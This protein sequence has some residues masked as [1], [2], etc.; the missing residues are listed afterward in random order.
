MNRRFVTFSTCAAAFV[1]VGFVW[2]MP[3]AWATNTERFVLDDADALAAGEL[4]RTSVH[5]DGR[6]TVGAELR[7]IALPDD[8]P[9]AYSATRASDGTI[10][11]GT[12]NDGRVYRLRGD[13]LELFASTGQLMVTALAIGDGGALYAGTMPE[14]R[15]YRIGADGQPNEIARP[16]GVEHVWDVAWD[17]RRNV[18]YA[19]TGPEGRVYAIDRQGNA[20]IYWDSS[21]SHVMSLALGADGALYAGTSDDA[22]VAR[23]TG[24]GHATIVHDFEGNEITA[25]AFRDGVLAVGANEF[26]DPPSLTNTNAQE[27]TSTTTT[28]PVPRPGKGRIWRVD[29]QGR[30]ER[31]FAQDEGHIACLSIRA[32]GTIIAGTGKDGR[33]VRVNPDRTTATYIDVDERQVLDMEMGGDDPFF[34]TADGAA[35]YRVVDARPRNAEWQ[36]KVL[37]ARFSSRWGQLDW[38]GDGQLTLQTRSGNVATPD[39]TWSEWSSDLARPG[40]IRSPA[41]RYLQIR[42]RF[43][44]DPDAALRA[45]TAY[46]L[47]SNQRSRITDVRIEGRDKAATDRMR[48]ERQSEIPDAST[49]YKL[50]WTVDNPDGDR[51][52]YRIRYRQEGQTVWRELLRSDQVLTETTYDWDT[53]AI[54]DGW[55]VVRVLATDEMDNPRALALD[56]A[57][58][59]EPIRIDNHAPEVQQLRFSAPRLA[60]RAVDGLGPI[61]RLEYAVDGL[62]WTPFFPEDDLFDTATET[63]AVDLSALASGSH[64]VAVRATDASGNTATAEVQITSP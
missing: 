5:S 47:P 17:A 11:V 62:D 13:A 38:R 15:I 33:I 56:D 51:V 23:I 41:A 34:V 10:Y 49:Q 59:S 27:R 48:A 61:A 19:A 46:F 22:V 7:R 58:D 42:A 1:S 57:R 30:V 6:V 9:I 40:P 8:V 36:S 39:D 43:E 16:D 21:A 31:V 35:L 20:Q 14:G 2:L 29:A 64:V 45:V 26:P 55:Y 24:P 4:V 53:N 25:L 60:G 32:D 54:A 3:S 18:L 50:A 37:D 44:R 12:G 63:F 28:T 52:R